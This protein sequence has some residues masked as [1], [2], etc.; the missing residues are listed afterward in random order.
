MTAA[1]GRTDTISATVSGVED[2]DGDIRHVVFTATDGGVLP[3]FDAGSHTV[4]QCGERSNAYSLTNDGFSPRSYEISVRRSPEGN[5]GSRWIHELSTGDRVSLSRPRSLFR[6]DTA[7]KH[8]VLIA[9]GIGV[10]PILSHLREAVRWDRSVRVIYSHRPEAS[11][12]SDEIATLCD[13]VGADFLEVTGMADTRQ[14]LL[15]V[16][17]SS[18]IGTHAYICGPLSMIEEF[19]SWAAEFNWPDSRVHF[20]AFAAPESDGGAPFMIVD[21][22]TGAEIPVG[23]EDTA[24]ES[25]EAA[26]YQVPNM[27]RQGVCGECRLAVTPTPAG[28]PEHRDMVLTADERTAGTAFMPCVSRCE[29][30]R[31]EVELP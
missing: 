28:V 14:A 25:L 30:Q 15:D 12:H 18:P 22:A 27:C 5:G 16:L 4:V 10:T 24:L 23:E 13:R 20:E 21:S 31:L 7:A 9:G 6:A 26:G 29:G 2:L 3:P 1:V 11:A 17:S 8:H 19:R